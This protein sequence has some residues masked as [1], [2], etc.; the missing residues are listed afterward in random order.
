MTL[1]RQKSETSVMAVAVGGDVLAV[2]GVC[3][4]L[5]FV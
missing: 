3:L 1:C 4:R 5:V 2:V